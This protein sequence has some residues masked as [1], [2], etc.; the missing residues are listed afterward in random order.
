MVDQYGREVGVGDQVQLKGTVVGV[1]DLSPYYLNCWVELEQEMPPSGVKMRIG[2]NTQQVEMT[3]SAQ[4]QRRILRI[5]EQVGQLKQ[6][7]QQLFE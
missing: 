1:N 7:V 4:T 2:L 6:L 3:K 5:N